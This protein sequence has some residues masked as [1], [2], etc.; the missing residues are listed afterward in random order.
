MFGS[1]DA[2]DVFPAEPAEESPHAE[3]LGP[4]ALQD[5]SAQGQPQGSDTCARHGHA[6]GLCAISLYATLSLN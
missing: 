3:D 6:A 5:D 4:G 1:P 2:D